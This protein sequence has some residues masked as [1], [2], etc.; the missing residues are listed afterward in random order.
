MAAVIDLEDFAELAVAVAQQRDRQ[1]FRTLYEHFAP[2]VHALLLRWGHEPATAEDITQVVMMKLWHKAKT[3][4]P[5]KSKLPTWL[6][7]IARNARV[8]HLRR[9]RNETPLEDEALSMPDLTPPPD[10]ALDTI[11]W[12][13]R[14]RTAL[15]TLPA[16]QLAIIRL[17]YF[18]GLTH[19]EIAEQTGQP[20]GTVKARIR[21]ALVRLRRGL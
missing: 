8:D 16:E 15:A 17:H 4:D 11:R 13:E 21:L 20:L 14:V 1:A 12:E 6:F 9:Q 18:E 2:R 10:T 7:Q 19:S 5:E 3:F